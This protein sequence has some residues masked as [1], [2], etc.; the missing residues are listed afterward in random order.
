VFCEISA[1]Q[2]LLKDCFVVLCVHLSSLSILNI[3]MHFSMNQQSVHIAN[4]AKNDLPESKYRHFSFY[5][6]C[7]YQFCSIFCLNLTV[8]II[9]H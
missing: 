6:F 9:E 3:K 7:V 2:V 1:H 8:R 4:F 5:P